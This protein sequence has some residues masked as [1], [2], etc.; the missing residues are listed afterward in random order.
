M[1]SY[2]TWVS[3]LH[4]GIHQLAIVGLGALQ[5]F[6]RGCGLSY[7]ASRGRAGGF[8]MR[9]SRMRCEEKFGELLKESE[10]ELT[11]LSPDAL[12]RLL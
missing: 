11:V 4:H 6:G 3:S 9:I 7:W 10:S 2:E 5:T 12:S 1:V 8:R